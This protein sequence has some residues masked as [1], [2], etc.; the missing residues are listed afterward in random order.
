MISKRSRVRRTQPYDGTLAA[1]KPVGPVLTVLRLSAHRPIDG[2][3]EKDA[4]VCLSDG[5][6]EFVWNLKEA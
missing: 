3:E 1:G 4:M 2:H 6:W 5:S